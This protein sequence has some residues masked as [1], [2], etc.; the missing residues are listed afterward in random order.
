MDEQ[1]AWI[2]SRRKRRLRITAAI[3]AFCL[4]VTTYPNILETISAFA[5]G[6]RGDGGVMSITGFV[7]LPEE[8]AKQAVPVGTDISELELPDTLEAYVTVEDK[9]DTEDDRKPDDGD[10]NKD[11]DEDPDDSDQNKDDEEEP[12]EDAGEIG[13]GGENPDDGNEIGEGD[14]SGGSNEDGNGGDENTGDSNG[15]GADGTEN[16]G[17]EETSGGNN[18]ADSE[19]KPAEG[20]NTDTRSTGSSTDTDASAATDSA[21]NTI[22]FGFGIQTGSFVMPVYMSGN[23]QDALTVDT[24]TDNTDTTGTTATTDAQTDSTTY[25]QEKRVTIENITW[26]SSPAYDGDVEGVYTFT[27]VLPEGYALADGVS[28][29]EITVTVVADDTQAEE[30]RALM[31]LLRALPDPEEYLTYDEAEDIIT[32]HE[33]MID[34][35]Q[36]AEAREAADDYLDKYPDADTDTAS[37]ADGYNTK[38]GTAS[39]IHTLPAL[40]T[41]LEGLEHIRDTVADCMDFD[42]PYHYPQFVQSRMA[43]DEVPELLTLEDLVEDYG[44]EEPTA[45]AAQTYSSRAFAANAYGAAT[46]AAPK[47][48]PQTLMLTDDNENNAHTGT[49]DGDIDVYMSKTD[50]CHPI[51]ISFTLDELPT[52]SAYLAVKAYDVDEEYGEHDYVYLN[53]DIYK[54]MDLS[55]GYGK[56]YN[57]NTIGYLTGTNN[58]WNTT[59]LEIPLEKLVKGKNVI[60]VTVSAFCAVKVDWM[61]LILDGGANSDIEKFSLKIKD[62]VTKDGNVT[63]RSDVTVKQNGNTKYATEYTLTQE[64]SSISLDAYFGSASASE[65]VGLTM[66][67]DS[68]T[69]VYRITGIL[70]DP[71]TEMIKATDSITFGF[72]TGIGVGPVV[73]HTLT[74]ETF[75]NQSVEIRVSAGQMDGCTNVTVS[76]ASWTVAANGTYNFTVSYK[77]G[78]STHSFTYPVKVDKIDRVAPV[79]AYTPVTVE[80]DTAYAEVKALFDE[81]L[82]ATDDRKLA[83]EPFTYTLPTDIANIPGTKTVTV[84]AADAAGNKTTKACD[85][86]VTAKPISLTMGELKAV[87]GSKDSYV[88]K[89]VLD[90]TGADTITETGFVWGVMQSPTLDVKNGTVKTSTVVKTKGGTLSANATGLSSGVV[91][92]GRAYAKVTANG[93]TSVVY[94]ESKTFGFGIPE[95]GTFS[96]SGVSGSTF[97]ISRS[98]GTDGKQTVYYRT[99]NG[100]AIGGTHFNHAAGSVTFADGESSKTVTVT[101]KGVTTAYGGSTATSYSNADRTYSFEIYRVDGGALIN[102][103]SRTRTRTMTKSSSYTIDRTIYTTEKSRTEVADTSGKSGKRIADTTGG[104]GGAQTNVSFLTN[105][106]KEKNYNTNS[107]FST[108]YTNANQRAYLNATAGGWYYR[109]VLKAYEDV[110]GYEYAYFGKKALQD[111]HYDLDGKKKGAA[112]SGIDG[113]LWMC[114]F[115]Q[116][117]WSAG[118]TYNFPDTRTGGGEG[119]QYPYNSSGTTVSYNGQTYVNLGLSDTCYLY[120]GATG[121]DSD[122]WYVDGLVGYALVYD[123]V[124]PK[125]IGVAP[126]AGGT[127]LPG[128]AITV[129]LVF[130]EIVDSTN[131]GDLSK[132]AISTNVGTLT[133]AGGA[134]TNVLYFTG[135]VSSSVNLSGSSALKVTG[136]TN[137]SYIK[138]MCNLAGTTSSFTSRNTNIDVDTT[139]PTVTITPKT[140]GSLPRHQAAVTATGAASVQYAWTKTTDLPANGWQTTASGSTLTETCGTAGATETW[141]LHIL[142]TASSGASTHEYKAFTFM[143]PGITGVSVRETSSATSADVADVWKT[144]KYIVVQYAGA[145]TSGVTLTFD[146]PQTSSQNITASSG[147]KYL[148][149]TKNGVYTITLKDSY[150]NVISRTVEVKKID[151]EK[152]TVTLR[153]GS[154]TGT[155]ATYNELTIAVSPKDTGGSGIAKVEYAWTNTTSAPSSWSTLT[156]AA[157]GSYQ[158]EYTA[159]ETTKMAKYL[160]VRVTDGAGNVST[161]ERSGPYQMLKKATAAELPTITVTGNPTAWTKNATLTWTA[162]AGTGTVAGTITGVYTPDSNTPKTGTTGTCTVTKNGNYM[163]TVMDDNGNSATAEV[164]VT[165][166]DSEAPKLTGITATGGKTGTITLTGVTDDLTV[167]LDAKGNYSSTSGSGIKTREYQR[168]GDSGWTTFT[169]SSFLVNKTGT[170]NVRMT[171]NVGNVSEVYS[172]EV[173]DID[174]TAPILTATVNATRNASGWYTDSTVP[175]TLTFKDEAGEEGP[176]SGIKSVEYA[177]TTKF[178]KPTSFTSLGSQTVASGSAVINL[179]DNGI[180]YLYCRVTDQAGNVKEGWRHGDGFNTAYIATPIK[181]DSNKGSGTISGPAASQPA[182]SGLNMSFKV[183]YGPSGGELTATGQTAPIATLAEHAGPGTES[184]TVSYSTT[185]TGTNKIYFKPNSWGTKYYWTYYVRKVT[186]DSQGGSAVADQLVWTK[187][188]STSTSTSVDCKLTKPADPTRTGYE[189]GGWYTDAACTDG[190]EFDFANQTQIRTDTTL[191]AKWTAVNYQVTYHLGVPQ[192]KEYDPI[193]GR[194]DLY[195]ETPY[196]ADEDYKSYTYGQNMTLPMPTLPDGVKGFTFD[197]WYTNENYTGT[198]YTSIPETAAADM[199]YYARWLDIQAPEYLHSTTSNSSGQTINGVHWYKDIL[200]YGVTWHDDGD[201]DKYEILREG[202]SL[203]EKPF[204]QNAGQ[205][206]D[207]NINLY[208]AYN[209]EIWTKGKMTGLIEGDHIYQYRAWDKAGNMSERSER[210]RLDRTLPTFGNITYSTEPVIKYTNGS[211][212]SDTAYSSYH[213]IKIFGEVP[214][215]SI[216]VQDKPGEGVNVSSGLWKLTYTKTTLTVAAG[217]QDGEP[218]TV[219]VDLIGQGEDGMVEITL[220]ENWRGTITGMTLYDQAGNTVSVGDIGEVLVDTKPPTIRETSNGKIYL[221]ND[222]LN[223]ANDYREPLED[224]WYTTDYLSEKNIT[225][226]WGSITDNFNV[227]SYRWLVNGKEI[228]KSVYPSGTGINAV[229]INNLADY[230]GVNTVMLEVTDKAGHVTTESATI[231]IKG[232]E[233]SKVAEQTPAAVCDYPADAIAQLAPNTQYALTVEGT[234]YNVTTDGQGMIPFELPISGGSTK[235]ICGKTVSIVKKGDGTN[236]EDSAAQSLTINARPNATAVNSAEVKAELLKDADDAQISLTLS[237]TQTWEYQV[238]NSGTW[239]TAPAGADGKV[240]ITNLPKGEIKLRVKAQANSADNTNDGWPHG[241]TGARNIDSNAGKIMVQYDLNGGTSGPTDQ[242]GYGYKSTLK[243]PSNPSRAGYEFMGWYQSTSDYQPGGSTDK[244]WRFAGTENAQIVGELLGTDRTEYEKHYDTASKTYS[245]TLYAGW[246]ENVAPTLTPV[247]KDGSNNTLTDT[248]KWY[249]DLSINLTYSDNVGVTKLYGKKDSGAYTELSGNGIGNGAANQSYTYKYEDLE[250]GTHTYTFKAVDA[251]GNS[252]EKTVT[253][254]LDQTAPVFGEAAFNDGYKHLW[255][256]IIRKESLIITIP[257]TEGGSGIADNGVV[258]TL[259]PASG[260]ATTGA[261]TM[262]GSASAGYTAKITIPATFKGK[263]EIKATDKAG[264]GPVIMQIGASGTGIEGVIVESSAPVVTVTADRGISDATATASSAANGV[265]VDKQNYYASAPGLFVTVKDEDL[266]GGETAAGLASISWRIGDGVANPV[267]ADY[268]GAAEQKPLTTHSFTIGGLE[269]STG[270]VTVTITATDQAGNET[271]YAVTLHIKGK[272]PLPAPTVDYINEKL[273][274]LTANAK[275]NIGGEEVIAKADGSIAIKEAWFGSDLSIYRPTDNAATTLDSDDVQI[276]LNARPDAPGVTKTDETIKGKQD[277]KN[278]NLDTTMEYSKDGGKTWTT[279]QAGDLTGGVMGNLPAGEILV[280]AKAR[281]NSTGANDGAPHGQHILAQIEEGTPLTI[282]FDTNGGSELASITGLSWND[283]VTRPKDP[284]KEGYAVA[285]WYQEAELNNEWYF[286]GE[287]NASVMKD[288]NGITVDNPGITLYAKW[289]DNESPALTAQLTDSARAAVSEKEWYNSLAVVLTYSDN[290][291]VTKLYVKKDDGAYTELASADSGS[292]IDGS[293]ENGKDAGGNARY[294]YIYNDLTEGEHTYTFKAVDAAGKETEA[295]LTAKLDMT[296]PAFGEASYEEGYKNLWNWIIKKNSL[297]ITLPVTEKLSGVDTV[298]YILTPAKETADGGADS[299]A[300]DDTGSTADSGAGIIT[301]TATVEKA[302]D[303][304]ADYVATISIDPDFKGTVKIT[305]SD[306]AGNMADEK[307]IGTDGNGVKGVIVEDNAPQITVLADRL[308]SEATATKPDGTILSDALYDNAPGL[309]VLLT[310]DGDGDGSVIASGLASVQYKIGSSAEKTVAKDYNTAI[311]T[312]DTFTIPDTETQAAAGAASVTVTITAVDQAGNTAEETVT[313]KLKSREKTPKTGIGYVAETLTGLKADTVYIINDAGYQSDAKGTITIE[314]GWMPETLTIVQQGNGSTTVNSEEQT[315]NIPARPAA[316]S[317]SA[318]NASY[319]GAED[320]TITLTAPAPGITYEISSDG[321]ETWKDAVFTGTQITGLAA[322]DYQIRVK[323]VEGQNFKSEPTAVTVEETPATPYPTPEAR[324][325][326]RNET[327]TGLVPGAVYE[328][329]YGVE[330]K[331]DTGEEGEDKEDDVEA[332]PTV[333]TI[334]VGEDGTIKIDEKWMGETFFYIV[335]KGNDKDKSDSDAKLLPIPVRPEPPTPTGVDVDRNNPTELAKLKDLKP[336]TAYDVSADGGET[337]ETMTSDADGVIKGLD[338]PE[339]YVVRVS[340]TDS[341]FASDPSGD[342]EVGSFQLTV[343]FMANGEKHQ[344]VKVYYGKK[345]SPVPTVPSKKDDKGRPLAG[346]WCKDEDG[347][348]PVDFYKAKITEDMTV[349]ACYSEGRL[350]TLKTGA[351]YKLTAEEGSVSPVKL[352]GSFTFKFTLAEG[353]EK[354]DKF[355][356]KVNGVVVELTADDTYTITNIMEDQTVTVEGVKKKAGSGKPG[357]GT[358][359]GG[360]TD[361]DDGTNPGGDTDPGDGSNPGGDTDPGDGTPPTDNTP[362]AGDKKPGDTDDT[363]PG[364][365]KKPG[366]TD[367]KR[368]GD[369]TKPGDD[370]K[371]GDD[372]KPDDGTKTGDDKKP[373]DGTSPEDG[374]PPIGDDVPIIPVIIKDG[375]IVIDGGNITDG[376]NIIG[377]GNTTDGSNTGDG[378]GITTGNLPGMAGA[379]SDSANGTT[380]ESTVSTML[381]I[382]DGAVIVTVVCNGNCMAG[383]ADTVA[384]ANAA[385]TPEQIQHISDG[386]TI[387]IRI[388]VT[389][390]SE[391]VPSQDKE[392]IEDAVEANRDELTGLVPG[393]YMDISLFI[394]VGVGEWNA[395]TST[396]EP[397]DIIIGLPEKLQE[398]GRE[399]YIIRSHEGEY[400]LLNDMDSAPETVTIS[401]DL[402][403]AYAIAFRQ[404]DTDITQGGNTKCGLCHICPTFLGICCFIWL[405]VIAAVI[406]VVVIVILRRKKETE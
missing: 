126:M 405:A 300:G 305:G 49:A 271:E 87:T 153:S 60:S 9:N 362:P 332:E 124:E 197:G 176:A 242:T 34:E 116:N 44:V 170:Y 214:T 136:I 112:I 16:P 283:T 333:V 184:A 74:P 48:H 272:M 275:Y 207:T 13:D 241:E 46:Y 320:G 177:F 374:V 288:G 223:T 292:G 307:T 342:V 297:N 314:G 313:I 24:M 118:D 14:E 268:L 71:S 303:Q 186:F 72:V 54:P 325:D 79:I 174:A 401:T 173:T 39:G 354:T 302:S 17:D 324:I 250:E 98:G 353:Y 370:K 109:Y 123:K 326:Y 233:G 232:P 339:T 77:T 195:Q 169:N 89:A 337:W 274:G 53:D 113:Q 18:D 133:Y 188:A 202:Q 317:G 301:G 261:A 64:S 82:S 138:D 205:K 294:Q 280:R 43:Q 236:T 137:N 291:E 129:S 5:A 215:I 267:G 78:S 309:V 102:Q 360:D 80:E 251:A 40:L 178:E 158:A 191:Y 96:V 121:A 70:K 21:A 58:T 180:W 323:A 84:T 101:E 200:C 273:T 368:P 219:T 359:P 365:D 403:S 351:G 363:K 50:S 42:C 157:D 369:D 220:P 230:T 142:A 22:S 93:K 341:N 245:V 286:K 406:L 108:Y 289:T 115:L 335:R 276:T 290:E 120:F 222:K 4:L 139:K 358:K 181:K 206:M 304:T 378:G 329:R 190:K 31:E 287:A 355:A 364:D 183:S 299:G 92:Y 135:T 147:T 211:Y 196:E 83:E 377:G 387:E 145:Q 160:H 167:I 33:D 384:V 159:T 258:Y 203:G 7:N 192:K 111:K 97:T 182:A 234:T 386:K 66:P 340:A 240:T 243:K 352:G 146:G 91:Y 114:N 328:L 247:L 103:S 85:I 194:E 100:S 32:E 216:P 151:T 402:F 154:S 306:K 238:P 361:P 318:G 164:L 65:T 239:T 105:R 52:Q 350:V 338:A 357:G 381:K 279:V 376:G 128:D 189:F 99:I 385:L 255:D 404:T 327:L 144:S 380:G 347:N 23:P 134:D 106:Y 315:L 8:T 226:I 213:K 149:V 172:V 130:D 95:Y 221:G 336:N 36:L 257:V 310:D 67:L 399:F 269:G 162:K 152:P 156:A 322:G 295:E 379:G 311:V 319:P 165:K 224:K 375:K 1:R 204:A 265:A 246:R 383:V 395:V 281:A 388:E 346:E 252:T 389:D 266:D 366:D 218:E 125:C 187:Q 29:P 372:T 212:I 201:Y 349:Y 244:A 73:S 312:Q 348:E 321:G 68:P 51:E 35:E 168:D 132:V 155:D 59:V 308:P 161:V 62:T 334:E 3:L 104:Q 263:V 254:K 316:P 330:V 298:E 81:A 2:R 90:H 210:I 285:G 277:G 15:N 117:Y 57:N 331:E 76:P 209:G 398:E 55:D 63:I 143:Q 69:G 208:A 19:T 131:S 198:R 199:T 296:G 86:I 278:H 179:T 390:I 217:E 259:T 270:T 6:A 110:D 235:D 394:R 61:Q 392:V 256:W 237:G 122:V 56:S 249:P 248:S 345:L 47:L 262:S 26:Q 382:G 185:T 396:E 150:G 400:T 264:N 371:P 253:A 231:K 12:D 107:S 356:V 88:L 343:T 227:S 193:W 11:D 30:L 127:Y 10:Q 28:L 20:N 166:V 38:S 284:V 344:E 175:V 119:S 27:P 45:P 229:Y 148:Q 94:S 225:R 391:N 163:F 41:R 260:T 140:S 397:F 25:A 171:D 367:D 228:K 393:M 373:G 282:T 75:T 293:A 37:G 141:Y